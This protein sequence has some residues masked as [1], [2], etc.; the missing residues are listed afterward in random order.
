MRPGNYRVASA[1]ELTNSRAA[2]AF[3]DTNWRTTTN[4]LQ[5]PL[6]ESMDFT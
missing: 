5:I 4:N 2:S 6:L 3:P 1:F